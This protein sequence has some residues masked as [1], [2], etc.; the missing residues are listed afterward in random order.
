MERKELERLQG[1]WKVLKLQKGGKLAPAGIT[2]KLRVVVSGDKITFTSATPGDPGKVAT[3]TVDPSKK[4]ATIDLRSEERKEFTKG[5]YKLVVHCSSSVGQ[6]GRGSGRAGSAGAAP[7][8]TDQR[9]WTTRG[10]LQLNCWPGGTGVPPVL[11]TPTGGTPV[12]PNNSAAT[13]P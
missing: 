7:S 8:P 1:T 4:P 13:D 12:P 9:Q 10:P 3:I 6:G 2:E 5:I 11:A